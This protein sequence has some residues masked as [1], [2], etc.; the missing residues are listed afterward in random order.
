[1]RLEKTLKL[2]GMNPRLPIIQ[3]G[4][5]VGISLCELASAVGREE[6]IGTVSSA[7]LD[8]LVA[9]RFGQERI[10]TAKA[11]EIEISVTKETGGVAAIN[12]M[13]ALVSSY[14][15]SVEGAIRGGVNM[16]ISGAGLPL[17]L[18]TL[19]KN[20]TGT[21]DHEINLVPIISSARALS[22]I[23]KKWERQGYRPDAVVLE[24]PKAGGHIGWKYQQVIEAEGRFLEEYDLFE[25]L[26]DPVLDVAND[27]G[28]IPVIVAGGI[29]THEDI[30]Y[31]LE[32]G[33][34]GVQ[35]GTRFAVTNESGG[36]EEFKQ[37]IID[38][39]KDDIILAT[40][41]WGSPCKLPFRYIR[42]SRLAQKEKKGDCFCICTTLMAATGTDNSDKLGSKEYPKGCPERYVLLPKEFRK[43][44]EVCPATGC[45][46]YTPLVSS[47]SEGYRVNRVLTTQ[48][49]MHELVNGK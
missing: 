24:G 31:A 38:A 22:L 39:E 46:D 23:C 29:Y 25:R 40:E 12:I 28:G 19:A 26:L 8:Q 4:M 6:G 34:T 35:M 17:N 41:D 47:G 11:T 13:C 36:S 3:G 10:D 7:G 33:A 45:A 1:M 21:N 42:T 18:P 16:I 32:R 9:R 2:K 5:G 43:Q 20:V 27:H 44:G 14:E 15:K 37:T 30:L 48:E 49:L